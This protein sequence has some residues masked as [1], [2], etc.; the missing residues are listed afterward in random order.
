MKIKSDYVEKTK[1][2]IFLSNLIFQTLFKIDVRTD[3]DVEEENKQKKIL[4]V[5]SLLLIVFFSVINNSFK[6]GDLFE[7]HL[8]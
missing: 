1:C 3:E 2:S 8:L 5:F 7:G 4:Q 6:E